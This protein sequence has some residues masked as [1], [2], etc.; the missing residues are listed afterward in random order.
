M[1]EEKV[2]WRGIL[3]HYYGNLDHSIIGGGITHASNLD[4]L[5]WRDLKA[6]GS[7]VEARK[8]WFRD[9]ITCKIGAR[10]FIL[11]WK[12]RWIGPRSLEEMFPLVYNLCV[13]KFGLV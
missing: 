4:S 10:N 9:C 11:F 7:N 12:L 6:L 13:L 5:W 1:I 3:L 8:D 2:V